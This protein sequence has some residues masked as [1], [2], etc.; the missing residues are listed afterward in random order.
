MKCVLNDHRL[1]IDSMNLIVQV[2]HS[3]FSSSQRDL[4]LLCVDDIDKLRFERSASDKETV[5]VRLSSYREKE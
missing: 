2:I 1:Q 5:N 4:R 3:Q